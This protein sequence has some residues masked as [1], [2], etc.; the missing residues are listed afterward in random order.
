MRGLQVSMV[1]KEGYILQRLIHTHAHK[2]SIDLKQRDYC[3]L[4]AISH[5]DFPNQKWGKN[6]HQH[7][8]KWNNSSGFGIL[9]YSRI[10]SINL[11]ENDYEFD[12]TSSDPESFRLKYK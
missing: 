11:S 9:L 4:M 8:L 12:S 2:I 10:S 7:P 5:F 1:M 3:E 6:E